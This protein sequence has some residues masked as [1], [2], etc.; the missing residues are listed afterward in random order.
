M[1]LQRLCALVVLALLGGS[2]CY[3]YRT[4]S[5]DAVQARAEVRARLTEPQL[6]ALRDVMPNGDRVIE[7]TVLD[8]Q[9]DQLLLLVPVASELRGARVQ[10]M[11][12]RI[13]VPRSGFMELE[14]RELDRLRTGIALA[15]G[16]AVL[17]F[18]VVNIISDAVNP[19]SGGPPGGGG[20]LLVPRWNVRLRR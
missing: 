18:V 4:V 2:A 6:Q 20:E 11:N 13:T 16:G 3:S 15:A 7:A 8:K 5:L 17:G 1:C 19:G 9:T 14:V 12:Q 10:T